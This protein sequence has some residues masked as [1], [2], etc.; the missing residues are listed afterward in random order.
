M[1]AE[2]NLLKLILRSVKGYVVSGNDLSALDKY[3]EMDEISR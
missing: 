3:T 2:Y 1:N